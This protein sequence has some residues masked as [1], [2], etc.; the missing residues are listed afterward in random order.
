[1]AG[2]AGYN[3]DLEDSMNSTSGAAGGTV[4]TGTIFNFS[5][6]GSFGFVKMLALAAFGL[7]AYKILRKGK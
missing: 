6:S 2:G 1:M 4:R 3:F 5:G 7:I